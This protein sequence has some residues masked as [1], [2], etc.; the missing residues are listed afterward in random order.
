[1]RSIRTR[2]DEAAPEPTSARA[3]AAR[4]LASRHAEHPRREP[5]R[6]A[7]PAEVRLEHVRRRSRCGNLC[8]WAHRLRTAFA[9]GSYGSGAAS[10]HLFL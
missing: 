7:P 4:G 5:S 6:F 8:L 1:M 10:P 2:W 3:E 9:R